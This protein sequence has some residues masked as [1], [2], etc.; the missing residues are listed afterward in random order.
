MT[1]EAQIDS[2]GIEEVLHFTTNRGLVGAL[3]TGALLSRRQLPRE[4]YLLHILHS[5]ALTRPEERPY[6]DKER[7]WLDYIN[8]SLSEINTSY[9]RFSGGWPHNQGLWWAILS[10]DSTIMTHADVYFA[11]TNNAYPYCSR[12]MG[13]SG[14]QALFSPTI[15]RKDGWTAI[16][17][18]RPAHLPTCEQ[19][20]VL[21]PSRLSLDFLKRIYVRTGEDEDRVRGFL[22]EFDKAEVP[23]IVGDRKF[24]GAPN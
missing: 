2:R 3:A 11:T 23:V 20:E 15:K 19:A 22:R 18:A 13:A 21:Y 1:I 5:N 4:Q 10:F 9:F 24:A 7:D 17:G 6:F 14:F 8:L 12:Q 16:R